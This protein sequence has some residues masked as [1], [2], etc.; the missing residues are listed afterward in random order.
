MIVVGKHPLTPARP[1]RIF[2]FG[3]P[4]NGGHDMGK[5]QY[6]RPLLQPHPTPPNQPIPGQPDQPETDDQ[7]EAR[8]LREVKDKIDQEWVTTPAS[9]L[10]GNWKPLG[11]WELLKIGF[12]LW[13]IEIGDI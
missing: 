2:P 7:R 5:S 12:G 3:P 10:P 11:R 6:L 9:I 4:T 1:Q 13:L 8:K